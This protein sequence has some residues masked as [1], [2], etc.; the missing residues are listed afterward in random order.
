MK[1]GHSHLHRAMRAR[2]HLQTPVA[3]IG[4]LTHGRLWF[5]K[6]RLPIRAYLP[7]NWQ[8]LNEGR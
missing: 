3:Q 2:R 8:D 1:P 6:P 7:L 4:E 5:L